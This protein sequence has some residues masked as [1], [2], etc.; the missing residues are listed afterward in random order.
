MIDEMDASSSD[1]NLT[2]D[3][4]ALL[5]EIAEQFSIEDS[6]ADLSILYEVTGYQAESENFAFWTNY[7]DFEE[8]LGDINLV[9]HGNNEEL[10]AQKVKSAVMVSNSKDHDEQPGLD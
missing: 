6:A 4:V 7:E 3:Q 1:D 5:Q 10:R 2:G 9:R 8:Q